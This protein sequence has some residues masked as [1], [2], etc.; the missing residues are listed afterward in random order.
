L[1]KVSRGLW[2]IS[3]GIG[4]GGLGGLYWSPNSTFF[5]HTHA[6]EGVPDGS[7]G[8]WDRPIDRLEIEDYSVEELGRGPLSPDGTKIATRQGRDIVVWSLD[9]GEIAR[10]PGA[11]TDGSQVAVVWSPDGQSLV[12]VEAEAY[13]VPGRS[14][15]LRFDLPELDPIVLLESEALS[16]V[17][18]TWATA[19]RLVLTGYNGEGWAYVFATGELEL[20]P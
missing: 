1:K 12:Y 8:P 10:A 4:A 3:G 20:V 2:M 11:A 17:S 18:A 19:E 16:F 9:E 6:R 7:C 15:A 13:C 5:Y 14:T